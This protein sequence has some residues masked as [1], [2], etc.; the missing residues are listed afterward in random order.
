MV[1][2][3]LGE[4]RIDWETGIEIYTS[5]RLLCLWN[6]LGKDTGIG[7]HYLLQEIFLTKGSKLGLLHCRQILYCLN[8]QRNPEI[9]IVLYTK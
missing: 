3:G 9:Y 8:H 7:Y 1:I 6:S 5:T 4:G 2:K